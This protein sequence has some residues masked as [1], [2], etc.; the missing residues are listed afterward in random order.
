MTNKQMAEKLTV[1]QMLLSEMLTALEEVEAYKAAM[2]TYSLRKECGCGD[3]RFIGDMC[4]ICGKCQ[5]ACCMC[6]DDLDKARELLRECADRLVSWSGGF[7]AEAV[8]EY[9]QFL[10]KGV[11]ERK[12]P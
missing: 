1:S 9:R 10:A 4:H 7:A 11:G 3:I 6:G 2:G 8:R 12:K 5:L